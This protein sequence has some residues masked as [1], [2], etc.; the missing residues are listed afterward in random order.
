MVGGQR[1]TVQIIEKPHNLRVLKSTQAVES[2]RISLDNHMRVIPGG[3][4]RA[5]S[6]VVGKFKGLQFLGGREHKIEA[7]GFREIREEIVERG[8]GHR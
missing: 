3:T 7:E 4:H 5:A 2:Q 1:G 6:A 8:V